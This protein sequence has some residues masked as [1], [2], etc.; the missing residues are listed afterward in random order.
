MS[1]FYSNNALMNLKY[2]WVLDFLAIGGAVGGSAL[3]AANIGIEYNPIAYILFLINSIA[4]V[5]IL[6]STVGTKSLTLVNF[7]FIVVNLVGLY[8]YS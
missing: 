1:D 3:M 6:R 5:L 2:K 7:Y 8:R 4:S